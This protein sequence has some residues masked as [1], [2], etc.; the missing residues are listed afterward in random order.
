MSLNA[1][2]VRAMIFN[3]LA[4]VTR[5]LKWIHQSE[6]VLKTIDQSE[7]FPKRN[8]EKTYKIKRYGL[9]IRLFLMKTLTL[10]KAIEHT[11]WALVIASPW[12][13]IQYLHGFASR[14]A[15]IGRLFST[16]ALI[17]WFIS[18]PWN[19]DN[20]S[21]VIQEYNSVRVYMANWVSS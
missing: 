12:N 16:H 13:I 3:S 6:R 9:V 4:M 14:R 2:C 19:M 10:N 18:H 21:W 20:I 7:R 1:R 17:G 8:R 15:L 5:D 11:K